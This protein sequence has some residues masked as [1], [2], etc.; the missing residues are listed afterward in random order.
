MEVMRLRSTAI[1]PQ[2]LMKA[3]QTNRFVTPSSIDPLLFAK[4]E[5]ELLE[6]AGPLG[7]TGLE[8]SPLAPLANCSAIA[9]ADQNKIVSALRMT[10]VVADATN[11]MA[12]E[13]SLRRKSS[14]F[15]IKN[16]SLC[17]IHRHVRAQAI[18]TGKGF[19]PHFKIFCALT[20]G[21]DVGNFEF[22][23]QAMLSHL[24][25]YKSYLVD[26]LKLSGISVVVKTLVKSGDSS[27]TASIFDH[28]AANLK[29]VDI[30]HVEAP[31]AEHKYYQ[32][33]RFSLNIEHKGTQLNLGDGGFVDWGAKLTGNSTER[34]FT[35]GIGLE[36][37]IKLRQGLL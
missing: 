34:M 25:L 18:D 20:A 32:H 33:T 4:A 27:R 22:E 26:T 29:G 8:L 31:W 1:T 10:E 37:L 5:V 12:L 11:L 24:R 9:L 30:T 2:D 15:D 35:S 16:I 7:F 14:A 36:L 28:I 6:I 17:T 19:T 21:K 13:S 23:K 3:Y